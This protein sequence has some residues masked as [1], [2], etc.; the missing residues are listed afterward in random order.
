MSSESCYRSRYFIDF[1]F[2]FSGIIDISMQQQITDFIGPVIKPALESSI[3]SDIA[4][5]L[6]D[7]LGTFIFLAGN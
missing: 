7:A 5:N 1:Y 6:V 3:G 2:Y 4:Q